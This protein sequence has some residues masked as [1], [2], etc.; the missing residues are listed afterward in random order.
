MKLL[1]HVIFIILILLVTY[2]GIG[3]ILM[4]DG[5]L[6]ERLFTLVIVVVIYVIL[7]G[8]YRMILRKIK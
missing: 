6:S 1:V 4:A 7:I 8:L 5:A 2:F 3:P